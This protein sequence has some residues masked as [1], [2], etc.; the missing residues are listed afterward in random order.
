MQTLGFAAEY[1]S[2][3][4]RGLAMDRL[5]R[6][7]GWLLLALTL[8]GGLVPTS[9][10]S[11]LATTL[12]MIKGINE[13]ADYPG[14]AGKRIAVVC[15]PVTSLQYRNPTVG[16]DLAKE[17]G[18]LIAKNCPKAHVIEQREVSEWAD[19]KGMDEFTEVGKA[20]NAE[21]VVL[22]DLDDFNLFQG[23][24][25]Y[26][27]KATIKVAVY[28]VK[29]GGAPVF[30][31]SIPQIHYPPNSPIPAG[32]KPEPEFRAQFVKILAEHV[33]RLFYDHDPTAEFANDSTAL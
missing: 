7:S 8:S 17:V 15:R 26:Q 10:C 16:R 13:K 32:D 12:W 29:N 11:M 1:I 24:G 3:R 28:D 20:L 9:G 19:E 4:G 2:F 31:K 30:E 33:S 27:G 18:L 23:Q 21:M 14:L 6:Q 25:L 22:L 5:R